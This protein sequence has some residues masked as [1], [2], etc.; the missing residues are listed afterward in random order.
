MPLYNPSSPPGGSTGNLQYNNSGSL[1]GISG[2]S[3]DGVGQVTLTGLTTTAP[4]WCVQLSGDT[5][6]RVCIGLDVADTPRISFGPGGASVRDLFLERAAAANVR[7]G[8][9]DATTPVA[10]TI[11]VQNVLTGTSNTAGANLVIKG[12]QGT[13]TG[14]GGTINFQ[15]APAGTTGTTQNTLVSSLVLDSSQN[16]TFTGRLAVNGA[17]LTSAA[18]NVS[19]AV[20]CTGMNSAQRFVANQTANT[21]FILSS[22]G[23][24]FGLISNLDS[25]TW[26]LGFGTSNSS[27]G[28]STLTWTDNGALTLTP[29]TSVVIA[30][31]KIFQIG[32][33]A[34]TGLGAGVLSAL[35]NSSIV[36]TDSTGQAYR[37][38]C[39]I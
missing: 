39:I 25:H 15:V 27:L 7:L 32:N 2:S 17:I 6:P 36:I 13:G 18:I 34:I 38:P 16:A 23:T 19:G 12:S 11:S 24:N 21:N 3:T 26:S 1:G 30:S 10:Q 29:T 8:Q 37:I 4:S 9:P 20:A 28:T 35:T 14:A 33:A 31:G 22:A 5:V